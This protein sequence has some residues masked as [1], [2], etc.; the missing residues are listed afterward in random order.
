[1]IFEKIK[2]LEPKKKAIT[3]W[4]VYKAKMVV[5]GS[6]KKWKFCLEISAYIIKRR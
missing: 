5:L 1:M 2:S 6:K 3:N 4:I